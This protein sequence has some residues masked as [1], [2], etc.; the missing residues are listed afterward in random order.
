M[1]VKLQYQAG[2]IIFRQG[3][4]GDYA[5][6]IVSGQVEIVD[7]KPDGSIE[8]IALLEPGQMFGEMALLD[9][10]PRSA[11]ARAATDVSLQIMPI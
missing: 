10:Q 4:P 11:T 3:Y 8:H 9:D 2:E 1:S 6:V 7:V 5:Y